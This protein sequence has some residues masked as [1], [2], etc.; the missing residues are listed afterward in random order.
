MLSPARFGVK[1]PGGAPGLAGQEIAPQGP[2]VLNRSAKRGARR[3]L[4]P[5]AAG[6]GA[7]CESTA[8][9]G[10]AACCVQ[11]LTGNQ[12]GAGQAPVQPGEPPLQE[13]PASRPLPAHI[14]P[15][16]EGGARAAA[17]ARGGP[18]PARASAR[19]G[20]AARVAP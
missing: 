12:P 16:L 15:R 9:R 8:S 4:T 19:V 2:R 13:A 5:R 3:C 6:P 11:V 17:G 18:A 10:V 7:E 1:A 20:T 14:L